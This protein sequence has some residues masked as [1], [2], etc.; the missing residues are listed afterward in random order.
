MPYKEAI[1]TNLKPIEITFPTFEKPS[2]PAFFHCFLHPRSIN[3]HPTPENKHGKAL[4]LA[5]HWHMLIPMLINGYILGYR[6]NLDMLRK[7]WWHLTKLENIIDFTSDI[8]KRLKMVDLWGVAYIH[9]HYIFICLVYL[10]VFYL[11]SGVS[12]QP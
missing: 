12:N 3:L 5:W 6:A 9:N 8:S 11:Q 4:N 1:E 10:C 2:S 7:W